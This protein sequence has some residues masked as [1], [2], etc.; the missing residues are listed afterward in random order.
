MGSLKKVESKI[1][2]FGYGSIG[3]KVYEEIKSCKNVNIIDIREDNK[4]YEDGISYIELS[5]E[6]YLR[7]IELDNNI[8]ICAFDDIKKN[9][10]LTLFIKNSFKE[11]F[12]IAISDSFENNEKLKFLKADKV[13]NLYES[14]ANRV[15]DIITRPFSTK[16]L[17]EIMHKNSDIV[18]EEI[19][20]PNNSFL[21]GRYFKE[22]DFSNYE[23]IMI[24]IVDKELG[25]ELIFASKGIN[26]KFDSGDTL[27]LMGER[28][29][30][31]EF[32]KKL[33]G[34]KI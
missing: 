10:Y 27:V 14:S 6:D 9:I 22:I 25:D 11:S 28:K 1:F 7:D 34:K 29:K 16:V 26:H 32:Y 13:I 2:L 23:V 20:L 3:K 19:V 24:G 33:Y 31:S 17:D 12:V 30:I 21:E 4:K 15:V 5:D 8:A 18:I